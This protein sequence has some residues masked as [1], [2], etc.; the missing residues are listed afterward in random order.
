[1]LSVIHENGKDV[2]LYGMFSFSC[3]MGRTIKPKKPKNLKTYSKKPRF[4]PALEIHEC[5][6]C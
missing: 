6:D 2:S 1:M 5:A 4:F 3:A